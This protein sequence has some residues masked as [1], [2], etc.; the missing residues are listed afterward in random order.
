MGVSNFSKLFYALAILVLLLVLVNNFSILLL[1][2]TISYLVLGSLFMRNSKSFALFN[3]ATTLGAVYAYVIHGN[4]LY[5]VLV[6]IFLISIIG[7]FIRPHKRSMKRRIL[8]SKPVMKS[9]TK[10]KTT[11]QKRTTD[12][13]VTEDLSDTFPLSKNYSHEEPV[14]T[15]EIIGDLEEL[16][17]QSENFSERMKLL[18]DI[19]PA[20]EVTEISVKRKSRLKKAKKV[21]KKTIARSSKKRVATKKRAKKS[22][23]KKISKRKNR[24]K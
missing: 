3:I 13:L 12:S 8:R 24:R 1:F 15:H 18:K 4:F 14:A 11:A 7:S 17:S 5:F 23:A 19:V 21:A 9:R 16:P 20:E 22:K 2:A 6:I 10:R